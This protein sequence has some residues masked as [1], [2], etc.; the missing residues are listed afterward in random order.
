MRERAC[1]FR[2]FCD[3]TDSLKILWIL[4]ILR[5]L[6]EIEIKK[7]LRIMCYSNFFDNSVISGKKN[8]LKIL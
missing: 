4:W 7:I 1:E 5:I 3:D 6:C 2:D 8:L